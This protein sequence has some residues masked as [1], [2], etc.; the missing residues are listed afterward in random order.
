M[1][2]IGIFT[3]KGGNTKEISIRIAHYRGVAEALHL[4][5][6]VAIKRLSIKF[7]VSLLFYYMGL[8]S[9]AAQ[10]RMT[11]V[12]KPQKRMNERRIK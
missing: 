1:N 12:G 9:T 11:I 6:D 5:M 3:G 7:S 10:Y 8:K 4:I 2:G